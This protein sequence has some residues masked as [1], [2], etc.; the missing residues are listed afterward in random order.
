[1]DKNYKILIFGLPATGHINPLF[2]IIKELAKINQ[3]KLIVYLTPNF[4]QQFDSIN[5]LNNVELRHLNKFDFK[6]FENKVNSTEKDNPAYGIKFFIDIGD[7]NIEY[8][9]KEIAA[10]KPHLIIYDIVSMYFKWL[11]SYYNKW[12]ELAKKSSQRHNLKFAP[13]HPLPPLIA[14]SP[15][16]VFNADIFPNRFE[17][18]ML[19]QVSFKMIWALIKALFY[20]WRLCFKFGIKFTSPTEVVPLRLDQNHKFV[21]ASL[22]SDLQPRAHLFDSAKY[23]FVGATFEENKHEP[24]AA[25]EPF[26]S[27]LQKFSNDQANANDENKLIYVSLGSILNQSFDKYSLLVDAFKLFDEN[28]NSVPTVIVS[29]HET[30]YDLFQERIRSQKLSIASNIVLVKS[31]PQIAVLKRACLFITHSGMN[32]TSESIHF[33]VPMVCVP[34]GA[35]QPLVAYRICDELGLG[36]RL[37]YRTM[38]SNDIY[39][40]VKR[41][42]NDSSYRLRTQRYSQLSKMNRGAENA[43][44]LI[45]NCLTD[46]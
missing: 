10:E 44:D 33:G 8:L 15:A 2:P 1:M 28:S 37:D 11:V 12:Y 30:V 16:F 9:A 38:T 27:L 19:I 24:L 34:I 29:M 45:I 25:Q 46:L 40:A 31:S 41:I 17:Q 6:E 39:L 43:R 26:V 20:Q 5:V 32:S 35:D 42:L 13:E 14:F 4:K 22:L 36:I 18:S 23:K 7:A 3:L 21:F